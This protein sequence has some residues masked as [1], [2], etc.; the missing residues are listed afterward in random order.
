MKK[1]T[2]FLLLVN[3][4]FTQIAV[5]Q[6]R[7]EASQE[8]IEF[9][10]TTWNTEW[11]SCSENGPT[12]ENLQVNNVVAVIKAINPDVLTLQEVG[13]SDLYT[14]IDTLVRRLG[15]EWGGAMVASSSYGNCGQNQGFIYKKA[16]IQFLNA[17]LMTNAGASYDWSS[18]RYP[19]L[20][21]V[22]L[23]ANGS[24]I[25]VSFINIHAKA[26]SDTDSY[27][28]RKNASI[29]L[30]AL[31][32]GSGYN[33]KRVVILGDLNDYLVGTQCS[34]CSPAESP[35]KN[36]MDDTQNYKCLT[37]TLY[38]PNYN[39][40][41]I[42]NII[43]SNELVENYKVNSTRRETV[44]TQTISDYKNTT[45]DHVPISV[46]FTIG[47]S[48]G[49]SCENLTISET[50]A[51]SLGNYTP[52]SVSGLQI[53]GW[54]ANYGAVMSG[55]ANA[56]NNANEDWLISPAYDLSAKSDAVVTFYHAIN[57]AQNENDKLTNHTLWASANYS[58]GTLPSNTSWTQLT[59]PTMA[60]GNSWT[61]VNSG[62][63]SIPTQLLQKD[64]RFAFKYQSNTTA[65]STWEIKELNLNATCVNTNIS[66]KIEISQSKI[67]VVGKRIKIE[68][69]Q[70]LSVS[71]VDITGRILF[72][73]KPIQIVEI[74]IL[75]SG[76]Y[77]IRTGNNANKVI[78]E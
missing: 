39:S 73:A 52:Y 34:S 7:F 58:N 36:F 70:P 42:D 74:P 5:S 43:I 30:K 8:S 63:I 68:N 62:N 48:G 50:F 3:F 41:V 29:G 25:P 55:Y 13:T 60:S 18:G 9:K 54:R 28:R 26:M 65:A 20:Y 2:I 38:D 51:E 24:L 37:N 46:T 64:I 35:Y 77:I 40:P 12:N 17:S 14:T 44:T 21:S 45:S 23:L 71:V 67:S 31:L 27:T 76:I 56:A 32:D 19:V 61:F 4:I 78:V 53:W 72:S 1:N 47:S 69:K 49:S 33:T 15:V 57:H 66:D 22:N 16:K 10:F 11:L 59:I 6:T 75:Q